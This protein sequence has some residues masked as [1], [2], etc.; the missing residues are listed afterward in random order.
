MYLKLNHGL[1]DW[2]WM[3]GSPGRTHLGIRY[4]VQGV[5]LGVHGVWVPC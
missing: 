1:I 5:C 2:L 3:P 4:G